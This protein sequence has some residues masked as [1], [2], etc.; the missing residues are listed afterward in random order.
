MI[1]K[2]KINVAIGGRT[3]PLHVSSEI[4]EQGTRRAAELINDLISKFE[5]NYAVSDKQDVLAMCALQFASKLEIK[6]IVEKEETNKAENKLK[7]M[8]QLLDAHLK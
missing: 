4:E 7:Q 3:Y 1:E 8:H 2:I 5:Q 6:T